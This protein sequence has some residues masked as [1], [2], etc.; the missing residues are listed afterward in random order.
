MKGAEPGLYRSK[1]NRLWTLQYRD[2]LCPGEA[3]SRPWIALP[4]EEALRFVHAAGAQPLYAQFA[5]TCSPPFERFRAKDEEITRP[6]QGRESFDCLPR[7]SPRGSIGPLQ[8]RS[9]PRRSPPACAP[10]YSRIGG[11][12]EAGA[13]NFFRPP[14][15]QDHGGILGARRSWRRLLSEVPPGTVGDT[16]IPDL[17]KNF[18]LSY[19][20]RPA[21]CAGGLVAR[22]CSS[23][24]P[25]HELPGRGADRC[26]SGKRAIAI[27]LAPR[28]F[29]GPA[30]RPCLSVM[31]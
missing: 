30:A 28:P 22:R 31:R 17:L 7:G 3:R 11:D 24:L 27:A 13:Y 9:S 21:A 4:S 6:H 14:P 25:Q 29:P 15:P 10:A 23:S 1:R 2:N 20:G 5:G 26:C 19:S 8:Q 18:D 16:A 12:P